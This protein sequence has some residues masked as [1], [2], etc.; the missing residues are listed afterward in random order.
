MMAIRQYVQHS[1]LYV[2]KPI[3]LQCTQQPQGP[4]AIPIMQPPPPV[5]FSDMERILQLYRGLPTLFAKQIA[6]RQSAAAGGVM[7]GNAKRERPDELGVDGMHKRRD[8]GETKASTP[9]AMSTPGAGPSTPHLPSQP[10]QQVSG[11]G[12]GPNAGMRMGSPSMPPPPV[13]PSAMGGTPEQLA[14]RARQVQLRQAMAAQQQ[15]GDGGRQM[16]PSTSMGGMGMPNMQNGVDASGMPNM[17]QMSSNPSMQQIWQILNTP[18]H[19]I[20]QF[21]MQNVPNFMQL[22]PQEKMQKIQ[23]AQVSIA[24]ACGSK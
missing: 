5:E 19:P 1:F 11:V 3:R 6:R 14:A 20:M 12:A 8:T 10:M 2:Y 22:S 15:L 18:N 7:N 16:S 9:S 4:M 17:Q 24:L 21:L 13:P 23:I